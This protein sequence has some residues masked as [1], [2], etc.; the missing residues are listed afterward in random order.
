MYRLRKWVIGLVLLS[1]A[2]TG[3]EFASTQEKPVIVTSPDEKLRAELTVTGGALRYHI[4]LDGKQIL[5]PSEIGIRTDGIDLDRD[6]HLGATKFRE[7]NESYRFF[8]AHSVAVNS[9]REASILAISGQESFR[10]EVHVAND[11]VGVRLL[12]PAKK[13]R[14]VEAD[15]ST[16]KLE[17]NPTL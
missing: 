9:A 17:G 5:A 14:K 15:L 16:W 1:F 13:G 4:L 3:L 6:V 8:G 2:G 10:V 12:L 7:V 11:G